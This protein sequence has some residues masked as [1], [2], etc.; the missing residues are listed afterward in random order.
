MNLCVVW[1]GVISEVCMP[2]IKFANSTPNSSEQD[3]ILTF[4]KVKSQGH[5]MA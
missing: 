1:K 5:S 2:I 3:S 4:W